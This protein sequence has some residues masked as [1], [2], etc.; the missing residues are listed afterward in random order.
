MDAFAALLWQST[1]KNAIRVAMAEKKFIDEFLT[2]E[3]R[4]GIVKIT[5]MITGKVFLTTSRDTWKTYQDLRFQLDMGMHSC[6]SLQEDYETTGLE[7]FNIETDVL[8]EENES[9]PELL[10]SRKAFYREQGTVLYE[11]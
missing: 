3:K 4:R 1:L 9:L 5:N 8:A 2:N 10:E 7:L 11:D 6:A